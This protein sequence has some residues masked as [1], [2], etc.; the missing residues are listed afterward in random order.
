MEET[1]RLNAIGTRGASGR[2]PID[3]RLNT[4]A[5]GFA[6]PPCRAHQIS[7]QEARSSPEFGLVHCLRAAPS[8]TPELLAF[9]FR[10]NSSQIPVRRLR[11]DVR[12][13]GAGYNDART[14]DGSSPTW[15]IPHRQDSRY[16]LQ[17][18]WPAVCSRYKSRKVRWLARIGGR[19]TQSLAWRPPVRGGRRSAGNRLLVPTFIARESASLIN[20]RGP[21]PRFMHPSRPPTLLP[22]IPPNRS[23][24]TRARYLS[25]C[26]RQRE[27]RAHWVHR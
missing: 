15:S 10:A 12:T 21:D 18:E 14:G 25:A 26:S 6:R 2:Q 8:K 9:N 5:A 19:S 11:I 22:D 27:P 17:S 4:G 20:P 1:G 3:C 13:N 24:P 16:L 23:D 7:C